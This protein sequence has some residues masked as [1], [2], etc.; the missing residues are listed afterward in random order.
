MT[1]S[2]RFIVKR[3]VAML[4][5]EN[6]LEVILDGS[7][8]RLTLVFGPEEEHKARTLLSSVLSPEGARRGPRSLKTV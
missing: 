7:E 2:R 3:L 4:D 1:E 6:E 5:R 8:G